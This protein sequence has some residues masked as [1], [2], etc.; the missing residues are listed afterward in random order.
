MECGGKKAGKTRPN[1]R[2]MEGEPRIRAA[3]FYPGAL[4][5]PVKGFD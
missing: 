4:N 2:K 5:Q 1:P 3:F